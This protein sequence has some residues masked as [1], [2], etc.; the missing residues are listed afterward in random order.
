MDEE[1]HIHHDLT[2][3]QY[4]QLSEEDRQSSNIYFIKDIS[5]DQEIIQKLIQE[6]KEIKEKLDELESSQPE[7][8]ED[9]DNG[10][11]II[12]DSSLIWIGVSKDQIYPSVAIVSIWAD[13]AVEYDR[14]KITAFST[15]WANNAVNG[16]EEKV[17]VTNYKNGEVDNIIK[18]DQ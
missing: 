10:D 11:E 6:I 15:I 9:E 7:P 16:Y 8:D 5:N 13:N 12:D 1:T 14:N 3:E 18:E 17:D 2:W 4:Q